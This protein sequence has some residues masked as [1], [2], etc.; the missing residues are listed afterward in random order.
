MNESMA[1][2]IHLNLKKSKMYRSVTVKKENQVKSNR[3]GLHRTMLCETLILDF[4]SKHYVHQVSSVPLLLDS[5]QCVV[6]GTFMIWFAA[7]TIN[8][9]PTFMSGALAAGAEVPRD[10][11]GC[12][13]VHGPFRHYILNALW[14]IINMLC[15]LL[16]MFHLRKLHR[17]LTK[18]N[19]EAV[20]VAGFL[21]SLVNVGSN[22]YSDSRNGPRVSTG[23]YI[24]QY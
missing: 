22:N 24:I 21:T 8:L 17:D 2:K 16:T 11:P 7:I 20:R 9:G 18:A 19:V 14:I 10:R 23:Y 12:P 3:F 15:V 4:E 5:P 1:N 6:F 13:L